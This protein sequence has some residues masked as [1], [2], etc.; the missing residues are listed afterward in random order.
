MRQ[1][2]GYFA[3]FVALGLSGAAM[4]PTLP[5]LAE[6]TGTLLSEISFLFT[7]SAAGYLVGSL[8]G[9]R[10]YD[11]LPGHPVMVAD[12]FWVVVVLALVPLMTNLWLLTAL[13]TTM[14]IATGMMDV[15][16]N[17]LLV[18]VHRDRVG[19]YMN[20]MHFFFGVGSFLAPIIIAQA[21]QLSGGITWAYWVLAIL[22]LPIA[23][24]MIPQPSP[25]G[26]G[27]KPAEK[28]VPTA[29]PPP[30]FNEAQLADPRALIFLI[31][32]FYFLYVGAE[33]GFGGWVFT[34]LVTLGLSGEAAAAYLTS[35]FWGALTV[36]R[37]LA[38]PIAARFRP[39][40]ILLANL[41]GC[42]VFTG[43]IMLWPGSLNAVW[44]GAIGL[45]L[46]MASIFP[47]MLTFAEGRMEITGRVTGWFFVGA[48]LGGMFLPWFIG[49]LFES[50]GPGTMLYAILIDLVFAVLIFLSIFGFFQ[51][52]RQPTSVEK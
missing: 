50:A 28:P 1:T 47:T 45:G 13:L 43:V 36:G 38:I 6:N 9:G 31:M 12:M 33:I 51:R 2:V 24:W 11:R 14:G 41:I 32:V 42:L 46:S 25:A 15:G 35:A 22:I 3:V 48:S 30:P 39:Y 10:L 7:A 44:V 52:K 19:P 29:E 27:E 8:V 34:Y 49:Q 40:Q 26:P 23:L 18:W 21:T 5:A 17:T 16:G 20:G 4:G 37:L